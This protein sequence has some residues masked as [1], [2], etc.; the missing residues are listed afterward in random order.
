MVAVLWVIVALLA[1]IA[2][3]LIAIL[4]CILIMPDVGW[5]GDA[6]QIMAR[7][8]HRIEEKIGPPRTE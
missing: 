1:L 4:V 5:L 6:I 7:T 8:L 3:I 2:V